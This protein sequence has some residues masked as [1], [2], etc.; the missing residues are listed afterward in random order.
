M[1]KQVTKHVL[2][3]VEYGNNISDIEDALIKAVRTDLAADP[4]YEGCE[5][6]AYAPEPVSEFR[7]VKRYDYEMT[8]VVYPPRSESNILIDYGII[9]KTE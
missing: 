2:V 5:T 1:D 4:K 9:E 8:G 6:A 3:A 7:R